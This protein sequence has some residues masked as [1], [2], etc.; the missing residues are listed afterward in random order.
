MSHYDEISQQTLLIKSQCYAYVRRYLSEPRRFVFVCTLVLDA[1]KK[2]R[3]VK[4]MLN[5]LY[6]KTTHSL[7]KFDLSCLMRTEQF[8]SGM[9]I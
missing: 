8:V 4:K 6:D 7:V 1:N 9:Q 3:K 5:I 2:S